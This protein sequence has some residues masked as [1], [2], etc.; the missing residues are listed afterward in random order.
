[1]D[2]VGQPAGGPVAGPEGSPIAARAAAVRH[3][4]RR[5]VSAHPSVYLPVA[6]RKHPHAT[7][8][9]D[10]ALV[11]DGFTR[12]AVTFAV[13][14]FQLAQDDHV[15][16]AHHLHAAG[17][18]IE[19]A[20][21]G[22]PTLVTVREPKDSILSALIREPL[23]P[24]AQF[25]RSFADFYERI[26]PYRSR[27]VVATFDEVT[28]DMGEVT[29]RVNERFGTRFACFEQTE[30]N[31]RACFALIE[32]RSRRPPWEE[33]LGLFLSGRM[34][35]DEYRAATEQARRT[36]ELPSVPEHRVQ[37][38]SEQR[39]AMKQRLR[40]RY[41]APGLAGLRARAE[42]AFARFTRSPGAGAAQG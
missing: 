18:L 24:P 34:S 9:R 20:R 4:V 8:D 35:A 15:R 1:M 26:L 36:S 29:A 22:V 3:V 14:A 32:E 41:E 30:E 10:T 23:V 33:Q 2:E 11:I 16:V 40:A 39:Q 13:V 21:R 38:P 7:L 42:R 31:V 12:S 37:R 17:H 19:A 5:V 28:T 27:F 6:R 25:L